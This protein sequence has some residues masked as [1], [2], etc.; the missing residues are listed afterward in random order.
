MDCAVVVQMKSGLQLSDVWR[1][2]AST[3]RHRS[4]VTSSSSVD[5]LFSHLPAN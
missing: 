2:V 1:G 3:L 4:C 5:N